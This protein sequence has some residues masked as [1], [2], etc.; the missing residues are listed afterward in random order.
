MKAKFFAWL[1]PLLLLA[2]PGYAQDS[3]ADTLVKGVTDDVMQIL[4]QDKDIQSGSR[5]KAMDLIQSKIAPH[6]DFPR[7]TEL[8]VGRAWRDASPEQREALTN[9]FRSLLVRTYANALT[10]YRNQT[11]AVKPATGPA[12][13][14]EVVVHSRIDQPG[15]KPVALDYSLERKDGSWK[16]Y[17]VAVDSVSLVTSYRSNFASELSKGGV[18]GLVK[19]LQTKTRSLESNAPGVG[20]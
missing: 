8:A 3:A 7:M 17:D 5:Q 6:F 10:N 18:D 15:G 2:T 1:L 13:A 12:D 11:V 19:A 20:G 4:R 9:E 14:S 16:V